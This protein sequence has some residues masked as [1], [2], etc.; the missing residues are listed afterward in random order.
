MDVMTLRTALV[1]LTC[2]YNVELN[3]RRSNMIRPKQM[4][5]SHC[6]HATQGFQ[7]R[8]RAK[9]TIGT[10]NAI[11]LREV[12]GSAENSKRGTARLTPY[13]QVVGSSK[14]PARAKLR[15]LAKKKIRRTTN[16]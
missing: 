13:V 3:G 4:A 6:K 15:R 11:M 1:C 8:A 10:Q 14:L 12:V 9:W 2:L 7:L 5:A 16:D